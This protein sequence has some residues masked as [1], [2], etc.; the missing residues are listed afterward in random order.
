M[1]WNTVELATQL[2]PFTIRLLEHP[3]T[4]WQYNFDCPECVLW[5]GFA[6]DA[7]VICKL[8]T[9]VW[10]TKNIEQEEYLLKIH[11]QAVALLEETNI[12]SRLHDPHIQVTVG[13]DGLRPSLHSL[14]VAEKLE[15]TAL[16][17][18][19]Y[20]VFVLR[21]AAYVH[22]LGKGLSAG[23]AEQEILQLMKEFEH[24]RHSF[25]AHEDVSYLIL[26][27]IGESSV[28]AEMRKTIGE[29]A[30]KVLLLVV[31]NH[32]VFEE[33]SD[34]FDALVADF[35]VH[36]PLLLAHPE[37]LESVLLTYTFMYADIL[38]T[39]KYHKYWPKKIEMLMAVLQK[40][41]T[42]IPTAMQ[43]LAENSMVALQHRYGVLKAD[44]APVR[45]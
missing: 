42:L 31:K 30:W 36:M 7:E 5:Q 40:H 10:D 25:P 43:L 6:Q 8:L 23:I 18:E 1:S 14:L 16:A 39:E 44:A 20:Q 32:H 13:H 38:A 35:N 9:L 33:K 15:T 19:Q 27:T 28:G 4:A 45:A 3:D 41:E 26:K 34:G 24:E 11:P 22:D 21:F 37:Q 2:K 29:H 17:L 12:F